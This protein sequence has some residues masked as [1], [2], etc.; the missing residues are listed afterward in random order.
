MLP[1]SSNDHLR[2]CRGPSGHTHAPLRGAA[3]FLR[4]QA[5]MKMLLVLDH[6]MILHVTAWARLPAQNSWQYRF[7]YAD[8]A[9]PFSEDKAHWSFIPY[10]G[11]WAPS[12][13]WTKPLGNDQIS[14]VRLTLPPFSSICTQL[15]ARSLNDDKVRNTLLLSRFLGYWDQQEETSLPNIPVVFLHS[16]SIWKQVWA[17]WKQVRRLLKHSS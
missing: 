17:V 1:K 2:A 12:W 5:A 9:G 11:I 3:N 8:L 10:T 16:I 15:S 13:T 6:S 7:R 4:I 14:R